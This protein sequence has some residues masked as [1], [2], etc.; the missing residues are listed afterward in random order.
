MVIDDR[1][2]VPP[3]ARSDGVLE[4]LKA[5]ECPLCE[6]I[7]KYEQDKEGNLILLWCPSCGREVKLRDGTRA[8]Y[9]EDMEEFR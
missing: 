2:H 3:Y 5:G 4:S 7:M 1:R 8:P 9:E 6:V